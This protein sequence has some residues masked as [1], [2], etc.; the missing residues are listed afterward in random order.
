MKR[1]INKIILLIF[2][3]TLMYCTVTMRK[4]IEIRPLQKINKTTQ[5]TIN[6]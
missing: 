2:V 5:D 1:H 3:S 6:K 4:S